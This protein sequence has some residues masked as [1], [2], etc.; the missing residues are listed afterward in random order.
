MTRCRSASGASALRQARWSSA[1]PSTSTSGGD[2]AEAPLPTSYQA[3][4]MSAQ[5]ASGTRHL[6]EQL[7]IHL[8]RPLERQLFHQLQEL[9]PLVLG[10]PPRLQVGTHLRQRDATHYESD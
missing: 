3:V 6:L 1:S 8:A 5:R 2:P 10:H 4:S 9:G 7:P